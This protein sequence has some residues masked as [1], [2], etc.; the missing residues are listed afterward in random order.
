[1]APDEGRPDEPRIA[2][3]ALAG[4]PRGRN[5]HRGARRRNDDAD[6]IAWTVVTESTTTLIIEAEAEGAYSLQDLP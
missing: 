3:R 4:P 2:R 5:R 6:D 1:M